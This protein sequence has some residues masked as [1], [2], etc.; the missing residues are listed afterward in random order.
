MKCAAFHKLIGE[1]L[2][3]TIKPRDKARL[4][5]HL[6]TCSECRQLMADF[7]HIAEEARRLD[8]ADVPSDDVWNAILTG[9]RAA[10]REKQRSSARRFALPRW[11]YAAGFVLAAAAVGLIAGLAPWRRAAAPAVSADQ[12]ATLAKLTEA[13]THYKLA[14]KAMADAL[15]AGPS[16]IG[17]STAVLFARDLGVV[18][19]ALQACRDA[20]D[21]DPN[22]VEARVFL[23]AAYQKKVEIL[24]R[25]LHVRKQIP[26]PAPSGTTL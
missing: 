12:A 2:E 1:R 17:S 3:G 8:D 18:D 6:E 14:I 9:V 4:E 23:L 16:V 13:E 25:V 20:V 11:S 24:D 10:R 22:S 5:A 19:S 15:G 21:R 7:Q 26:A